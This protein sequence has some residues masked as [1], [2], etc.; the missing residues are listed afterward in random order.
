MGHEGSRKTI[1][2]L[3]RLPVGDQ[4][5]PDNVSGRACTRRAE[6]TMFGLIIAADR[7]RVY[8]PLFA[9]YKKPTNGA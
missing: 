4:L 5:A 8:P 6:H 9:L 1:G 7:R 2:T 3:K